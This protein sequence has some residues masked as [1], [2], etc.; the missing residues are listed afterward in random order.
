MVA[1]RQDQDRSRQS[2]TPPTSSTAKAGTKNKPVC[3]IPPAIPAT[4]TAAQATAASL[5]T[6]T[7]ANAVTAASG[8]GAVA[9]SSADQVA[10]RGSALFNAEMVISWAATAR[11]SAARRHGQ[12]G[13]AAA[14][15]AGLAVLAAGDVPAD[16]FW[17]LIGHS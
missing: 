3:P 10:A 5:A 6:G 1:I 9:S 2:L 15:K 7:G 8:A 4:R 16:A 11:T 12:L 14:L 13:E 17:V